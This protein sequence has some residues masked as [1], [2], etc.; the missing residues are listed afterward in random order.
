M[1]G[2]PRLTV[3][4]AGL[5]F[6]FPLAAQD[7]EPPVEKAVPPLK[8]PN[9]Q[10]E[11]AK[12]LEG[13]LKGQGIE[14]ERTEN[15]VRYRHNGVLVNILPSVYEG[16][17]DRLMV[18]VYYSAFDEFAGTQALR[19]LAADRNAAQNFLRV[20]VD[21]DGYFAA[22]GNMTF[23]DEFSAK[24]YQAYMNLFSVVI[25]DHVLTE[26]ALKMLK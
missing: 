19:G 2:L 16:E 8:L 11:A 12:A 3:C 20:F 7:P 13:W 17:L 21:D 24:E 26:A 6:A 23:F 15:T 10:A 9:D 18:T 14:C 5:F 1:S 22:S 25:R 4:L